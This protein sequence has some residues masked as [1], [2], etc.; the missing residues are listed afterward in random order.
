MDYFKSFKSCGNVIP[1]SFPFIFAIFY[2]VIFNL[3]QPGV[4]EILQYS[5]FQNGGRLPSS[6]IAILVA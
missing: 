1:I 2:S 3:S 4:T 6:K 5:A